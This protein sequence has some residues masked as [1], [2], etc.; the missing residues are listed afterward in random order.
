MRDAAKSLGRARDLAGLAAFL[1]LCLGI[2]ALGGWATAGSVGTWYQTLHKPAFNPPD[3]VFGPV[4]TVLYVTIALAGWRI[5]RRH[6]IAG[7]R[8]ELAVY[9]AQ[10]AL[11]LGWSFLFFGARAIG[12]AF[13][14]ILL[15]LAAIVVNA[16]L[17]WRKDRAAGWLLVPYAV[18][19]AFASLLNVALWRLN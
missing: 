1:A 9:G 5:W 14:E 3:W 6:G 7:A 15:L 13:G 2:A 10:L 12:L 19:V 4:W 17:F 18:W 8:L 16:L 11:N